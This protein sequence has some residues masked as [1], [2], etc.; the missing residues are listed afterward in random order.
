MVVLWVRLAGWLQRQ[1]KPQAELRSDPIQARRP[2]R[3]KECLRVRQ[4]VPVDPRS[5]SNLC[6]P[7]ALGSLVRLDGSTRQGTK[8]PPLALADRMVNK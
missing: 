7:D 1:D 8:Y 6:R 4:H 5:A 2:V 3:V